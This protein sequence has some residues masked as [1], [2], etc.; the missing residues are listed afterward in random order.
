MSAGLPEAALEIIDDYVDALARCVG[1]D[2]RVGRRLVAE[3]A[4]HLVESTAARV[5]A[6]HDPVDAARWSVRA[7]GAPDVVAAAER[8]GLGRSPDVA[9]RQLADL[10]CR[11][12]IV[13]GLA[14]GVSGAIAWLVGRIAGATYV[15][16]DILGVTYT[17]ARCAEYLAVSPGTSDCEQAAVI[18]HL[19]E[20]VWGRLFVGVLA[21]GLLVGWLW[22]RRR[23]SYQ[24][25]S[26]AL[27]GIV[28]L[29]LTLLAAVALV[30]SAANGL[31]TAGGIGTGAPLSA[32]ACALLAAGVFAVPVVRAVRAGRLPTDR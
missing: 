24:S 23:P 15:V 5:E 19:D 17:P 8:E 20:V 10:G 11:L 18:D 26:P 6:G 27:V 30:L 3:A 4:D 9:L 13:G 28:G 25:A 32:A 14:I 16:G 1:V 7:F 21:V 31:T 22:W 12:A 29:A 2:G